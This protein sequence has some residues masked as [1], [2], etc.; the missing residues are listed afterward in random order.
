LKKGR[1]PRS[2]GRGDRAESKSLREAT[3]Q[4]RNPQSTINRAAIRPERCERYS[5]GP[6]SKWWTV[7]SGGQLKRTGTTQEPAPTDV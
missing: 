6:R 2:E 1:G 5:I 4:F 3:P 7:I